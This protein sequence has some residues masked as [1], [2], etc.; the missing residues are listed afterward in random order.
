[1]SKQRDVM[2]KKKK[3]KLQN[4]LKRK[5]IQKIEKKNT[6]EKNSPQPLPQKKDIHKDKL[7]V[8]FGALSSVWT[9]AKIAFDLNGE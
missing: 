5:K 9:A 1:M 7:L 8:I 3:Q 6:R 4:L 2:K